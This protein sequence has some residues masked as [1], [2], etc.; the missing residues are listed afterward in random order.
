MSLPLCGNRARW[1]YHFKWAIAPVKEFSLSHVQLVAEERT[2]KGS[3]LGSC[4]PKRDI[5][6]Y[7]TLFKDGKLPVDQLIKGEIALEDINE[8]FDGLDQGGTVRQIIKF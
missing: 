1:H 6:N 7:I 8:A 3:F 5:P 4:I 2:I